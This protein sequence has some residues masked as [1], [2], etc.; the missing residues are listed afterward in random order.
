VE[1]CKTVIPYDKMKCGDYPDL[2]KRQLENPK[3]KLIY[4]KGKIIGRND[5]GPFETPKAQ[6]V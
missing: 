5:V 1:I 6:K 4:E 2:L 3:Y